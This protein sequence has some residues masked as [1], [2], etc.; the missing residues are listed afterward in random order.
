[1]RHEAAATSLSWHPFWVSALNGNGCRDI[2]FRARDVTMAHLQES[3]R[4]HHPSPSKNNSLV[5]L[6][7]QCPMDLAGKDGSESWSG[8]AIWSL[9][10]LRD[11]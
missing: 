6:V 5:A 11:P 9:A 2:L 10:H 7:A 8:T 1:M 3:K 4:Q